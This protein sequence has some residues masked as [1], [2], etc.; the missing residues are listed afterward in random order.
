MDKIY[1]ASAEKQISVYDLVTLGQ[2]YG[3]KK[4][5]ASETILSLEFYGDKAYVGEKNQTLEI[6]NYSSLSVIKK[7]T[8][9]GDPC[10]LLPI[11]NSGVLVA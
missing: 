8:C 1:V 2:V 7:V 5:L 3:D 6:F 10:F 4:M 11:E 9:R